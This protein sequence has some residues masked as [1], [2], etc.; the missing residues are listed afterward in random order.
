ML[1]KEI[2][3]NDTQNC[4][5]RANETCPMDGKC[6]FD[7]IVYQAKVQ[8]INAQQEQIE[9]SYVGLTSDAFK[10][11]YRINVKSFKNE[12]YSNETC[13]ST[14]ILKLKKEGTQ[15]TMRWKILDRANT[16]C[17]STK[18]CNLCL[19]EKFYLITKGDMCKINTNSD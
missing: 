11:R 12:K 7:N 14:Y 9:E 15:Y 19:K 10:V 17:T 3:N 4:N 13:L 5:C 8:H 6:L 1:N 2:K 16:F 18:Q